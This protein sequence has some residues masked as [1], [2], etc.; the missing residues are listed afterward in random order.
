MRKGEFPD[1]IQESQELIEELTDL[2]E[3]EQ[4]RERRRELFLLQIEL[5][6]H[7]KLLK[8]KKQKEEV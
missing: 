4:D 1:S 5:R 3:R 8:L 7:I 2:A 6:D